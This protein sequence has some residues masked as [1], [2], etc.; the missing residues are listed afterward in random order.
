MTGA[1]EYLPN[2][3]DCPIFVDVDL[4]AAGLSPFRPAAAMR[5][6]RLMLEELNSHARKGSNFAFETTLSG[7]GCARMI[8]QWRTGGYSVT[9]IFLSLATPEE[10]IS[11]V[12]LRIGQGGHDIPRDVIRRRFASRSKNCGIST[13]TPLTTGSGLTIGAIHRSTKEKTREPEK[14][15]RSRVQTQ[16]TRLPRAHKIAHQTGTGIIVMRE[17]KI[18][19]IEPDP[20]MS[21]EA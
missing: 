8:R 5:A 2:E 3:T 9:L 16:R 15:R 18:V 14:F 13:A 4:I 11:R 21:E 20:E 19:E 1:L 17:G 10:A 12:I 7:Q 6:G